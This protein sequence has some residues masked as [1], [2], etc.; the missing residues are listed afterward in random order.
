MTTKLKWR[1]SKL[2]TIDEVLKLTEGAKPILTKE[3]AREILFTSETDEERD[4]KSLESEIKFLRETIEKLASRTQIIETIKTIQTPI[5]INQPWYQPYYY[6][7]YGT[8]NPNITYC[9]GSTSNAV[10]TIG[11]CSSGTT[12]G[13][14]YTLTSASASLGGAVGGSAPSNI[15]G[16][17]SS[18]CSFGEI[19][20]F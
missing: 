12:D 13:Q 19:K 16:C 14:N 3:E 4:K 2:P 11:Y 20:T 6:W 15:L 10:N 18:D 8:Y 5:Y 1:L 7:T 9:G 17:A